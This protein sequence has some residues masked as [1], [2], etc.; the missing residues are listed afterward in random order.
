MHLID[1]FLPLLLEFSAHFTKP[2]FQIFVDLAAGWILSSR[3]RYVTELIFSSG[4]VG[5]GHWSRYHRF[6]SHAKWRLDEVCGS[7]ARLLVRFF[8]ADGVIRLAVDDTLCRKRGLKLH[9]AGMH[10]DPLASSKS[11]KVFAWGH[12]WV[13][14]SLLVVGP[15]WAPNKVFAL[16][17]AFRLYVNRQGVAKGRKGKPAVAKADHRTRPQLAVELIRL[18]AEWFPGREILVTGDSLYGGQSVAR[19]L[20]A[21][22]D[23]ISRVAANAALYTLVPPRAPGTNG[24]P[25]KRG[26]RLAGMNDWADDSDSPWQEIEFDQFGLHGRFLVK[27][28]TALYYKAAGSRPVEIVLVRDPDGGRPDQMFYCTKL[29]W[30]ARMIL[31][32]YSQRWAI[33]VT[34][35]GSKQLLGLEDPANRLPLAVERTAPVG[36]ILYSLTVAWFHEEGH[37]H[38]VF[39]DRPWYRRKREPSFADML[40][41][42]RQL[43][44]REAF[45]APPIE[46]PADE[47]ILPFICEFAARAG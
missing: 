31:A 6:F 36:W 17:I 40:T 9:G 28:R 41:T 42:L 38:V 18:V 47:N 29:G 19:H 35:E 27:T 7:L 2:T 22:V 11:V 8:V 25:R 15:A 10:H 30:T 12:S 3:H 45:S 44:L 1:S 26:Q 14:L 4:N 21:N 13:V 5:N 20:P 39:P 43:S 32:G 34:F 46:E 33:E 16:P 23:L 37:R 24:R